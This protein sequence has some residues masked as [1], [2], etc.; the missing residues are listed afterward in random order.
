M[1]VHRL[2]NQ[3]KT[4]CEQLVL[5]SCTK[6]RGTTAKEVDVGAIRKIPS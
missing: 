4:R 1:V 2:D 6:N 3:V 5:R